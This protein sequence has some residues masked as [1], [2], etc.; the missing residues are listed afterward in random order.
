[1]SL[2][3]GKQLGHYEIVGL[4]GVGGMGEV[5][6]ATDTKLDR[7]VALKVLPDGMAHDPEGVARFAREAKLLA[8]L[9]HPQI[10]AIYG[11]EQ[12]GGKRFLMG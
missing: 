6:R 12:A 2:E 9:N 3:V 10:A 4:V 11:F 7:D 5:Y 1:M 8:S